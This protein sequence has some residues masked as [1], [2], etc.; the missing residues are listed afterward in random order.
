[1]YRW[2]GSTEIF[3]ILI[4]L[5][6]S[7]ISRNPHLFLFL[8]EG[9]GVPIQCMAGFGNFRPGEIW[10]CTEFCPLYT[11]SSLISVYSVCYSV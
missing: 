4:C 11:M 7:R 6:R 10:Q 1:M 2:K 8:L 9:R 3:H 5:Y